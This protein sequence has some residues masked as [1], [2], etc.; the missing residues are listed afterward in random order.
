MPF[1]KSIN[2]ETFAQLTEGFTGAELTSV[3]QNAALSAIER[4]IGART[5]RKS[6]AEA[7][8]NFGLDFF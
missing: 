4:D 6:A 3:C 5:V 1:D 7:I 8:F 2:P